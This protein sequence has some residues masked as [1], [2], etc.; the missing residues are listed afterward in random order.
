MSRRAAYAATL[1][2][3]EASSQ[4]IGQGEYTLRVHDV[5]ELPRQLSLE[6]DLERKFG[7]GRSIVLAPGEVPRALDF[8]DAIHPQP[9]N[10]WGME[11]ILFRATTRFHLLDPAAG[12]VLPGQAGALEEQTGYRNEVR[13]I[14]GNAAHLGITLCIPGGDTRLL[15]RLLPALQQHAPCRLSRKQWRVWTPT[16]KGTLKARVLDV[17]PF[18]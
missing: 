9:T 4:P 3:L 8:L 16:K 11:P 12:T 18:L 15:D 7:G 2:F 6:A 17:S 13:L 1:A 5:P 14:L 10:R